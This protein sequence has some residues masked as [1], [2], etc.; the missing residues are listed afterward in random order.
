MYGLRPSRG[1]RRGYALRFQPGNGRYADKFPFRLHG[2]GTFRRRFHLLG[3]EA[4][5][6]GRAC[7]RRQNLL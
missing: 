3:R 5:N 6:A 4:L 1:R 7:G 2:K